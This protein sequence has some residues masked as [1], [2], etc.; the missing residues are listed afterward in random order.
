M[1]LQCVLV[2]PAEIP[3]DLLQIHRQVHRGLVDRQMF[4]AGHSKNAFSI[5]HSAFSIQHSAF[6][7]QPSAVSQN[8]IADPGDVGDT[9]ASRGLRPL[10]A[11]I[12]K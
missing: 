8:P 10:L 5:Q 7:I 12:T 6:S 1:L 11:S 3:D 4:V 9:E 2:I